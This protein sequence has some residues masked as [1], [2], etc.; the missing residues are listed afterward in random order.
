[1]GKSGLDLAM[2][3]MEILINHISSDNLSPE[4]KKKIPENIEICYDGDNSPIRHCIG[5]HIKDNDGVLKPSRAIV[6]YVNGN[7][8]I[9]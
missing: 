1:M 2:S 4:E 3:A 5:F 6:N 8:K 7:I 9:N